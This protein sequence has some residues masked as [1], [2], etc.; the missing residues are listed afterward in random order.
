MDAIGPGATASNEVEAPV[1][2]SGLIDEFTNVT[3]FSGLTLGAGTYYLVFARV[4]DYVTAQYS[5]GTPIEVDGPGVTD[6]GETAG[7]PVAFPPA[8][9]PYGDA[10]EPT[11]EFSV[12]GTPGID[13]VP[14]PSS[15]GL[16]LLGAASLTAIGLAAI[17]KR[18][19]AV[20]CPL[21]RGTR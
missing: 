2:V 12:T 3:L 9:A 8:F 14:E 7:N 10:S 21:K 1:T 6:L 5:S 11:I 19:Y 17:R 13:P 15:A 18:Q 16:M 4:N 20:A